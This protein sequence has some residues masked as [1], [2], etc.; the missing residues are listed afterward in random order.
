M[1]IG[2][3]YFAAQDGTHTSGTLLPPPADFVAVNPLAVALA[4]RVVKEDM[5]KEPNRKGCRER[6]EKLSASMTEKRI[7]KFSIMAGKG[8]L[9]TR[10]VCRLF[11]PE[12]RAARAV[13]ERLVESG[14]L[15]RKGGKE[16]VF[17]LWNS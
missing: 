5:W 16:Q 8:W 4:T 10:Q 13:L 9:T 6:F 12:L 17:Y 14:H 3:E 1:I 7:A 15:S 11:E 2:Y